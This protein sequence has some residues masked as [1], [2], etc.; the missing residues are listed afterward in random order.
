M[1]Y[2]QSQICCCEVCLTVVVKHSW[3]ICQ[4]LAI[5][6]LPL[7]DSNVLWCFRL[8]GWINTG[9]DAGCP[10]TA[11]KWPSSEFNPNLSSKPASFFCYFWALWFWTWGR[12]FIN[13]ATSLL[14]LISPG[15]E[16]GY[17]FPILCGKNALH[18]QTKFFCLKK[19]KL[20]KNR[21]TSLI[22]QTSIE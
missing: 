1:V 4:D 12:P 10:L 20:N 18:F 3:K 13:V 17:Q 19:Q 7:I 16:I 21:D 9:V 15:L 8:L 22:S 5:M 11:C 6:T 2:H 14:S